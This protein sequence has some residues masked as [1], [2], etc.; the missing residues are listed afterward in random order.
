[1]ILPE[2]SI[3]IAKLRHEELSLFDTTLMG[4]IYLRQ[5]ISDQ[6][7]N[8]IGRID[9]MNLQQKIEYI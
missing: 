3:G 1:M 7:E 8:I 9:Y 4:M 2:L 6:L 5:K